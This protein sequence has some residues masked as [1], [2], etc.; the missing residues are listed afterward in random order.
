MKEFNI[1]INIKKM[2][3]LQTIGSIG[4]NSGGTTTC[5]IDL[6]TAINKLD[7]SI[8]LLTV[9]T[10]DA[11]KIISRH[12]PWLEIV[13]NDYCTKLMVS[14][15]LKKYLLNSEYDLY[16]TNGLW[17]YCNHITA[18]I[19]REKKK[20]FVL[21]PHGMLYPMALK[22]SAWKK[23]PLRKLWF[24]NDIFNADC[25]HA[26]CNQEASYIRK[27]GYKGP[28]AIIPNPVSIPE[29]VKCAERKPDDKKIVGFLGRL[30][31]RKHVE[32]L[33]YGVANAP[34]KVQNSLMLQIMGKGDEHYEKFLYEEVKRLGLQEIVE[35]VGFVSG[36][37]KYDRLC[38]LSALFVP[39][40]FEN[41]GMIVPEA[42]ICGTPVMAS[43]DTPWESLNEERC[44]W[45]VDKSSEA[46]TRVLIQIV[47]M[48]G[49][50]IVEMGRRGRSLVERK[51]ASDIVASKMLE[52]YAW[53]INGGVKP[54][55]VKDID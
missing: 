25:I 24:D 37:E 54:E 29:Y 42:L 43:L 6:M 32:N 46:I 45:W 36:K 4:S 3:I 28:I 35:F 1:N 16:H 9:G 8:K 12:E 30:H 14:Q 39:S 18:K 38:K 10:D 23:W 33:L 44:G 48:G 50:E 5:T 40:D 13:P 11:K 49:E 52:L 31:P 51:F 22:R 55:F 19:A 17:M 26:T 41:F 20:P 27:F 34:Q 2:N 7:G 53:I 21:T 47:E 15:N